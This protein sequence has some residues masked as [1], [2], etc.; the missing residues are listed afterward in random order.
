MEERYIASVDLGTSKIAVA[1]ARVTGNDVQVVYYGEEPS[2]GI[3]YGYIFNPL[4]ALAPFKTAI[5][6]A[7]AEL[8]IK[9]KQAVVGLPRY[10]VHQETAKGEIPRSD[11]NISITE[12]ELFNLKNMALENYELDNEESEIRYGA[13]AQSFNTDEMQQGQAEDI[14]GMISPYL[15]GNFK[16]FIGSRK[17]FNNI[18]KVF[19]DAGIAIVDKYFVPD[20]TAKLVLTSDEMEGGVALI[21]MGAGV[22][23]VSI[24]SRGIL[25]HY[26]SIPFGGAA[27]TNDI[28]LECSIT[29]PLAE[30][31]KIAFGNCIPDKLGP[32]SEKIIKIDFLGNIPE[33]E[34]PVRYLSE[35]IQA[36]E[37]EIINAILFE[38]QRSGYAD[39][40]RSGVVITGGASEM[41]NL[42][43]MIKDLSGYNVRVGYPMHVFS[44]SGC[45]HAVD[46]SATC[47]MSMVMAARE[48]TRLNCAEE[49]PDSENEGPGIKFENELFK[50]DTDETP[51]GKNGQE[52][53][54]VASGN[55]TGKGTDTSVKGGKTVKRHQ[56]GIWTHVDK[57]IKESL[58]TVGTLF[59]GIDDE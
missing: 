47:C 2:A 11:E 38:I 55:G 34:L 23:S 40:L 13:I 54:K 41:V 48:S 30:N 58:N 28:K 49:A 24:Y 50:M 15:E 33:K 42:P 31:I 21:D 5:G 46:T 16:V 3:R 27:I 51:G 9:I 59:D 7:E 45:A 35:I 20:S 57:A 19:N 12:E 18:D 6:K 4:K 22:T 14:I 26:A 1:V 39:E 56:I 44:A 25:R 32:D 53:G 52:S 8:G 29:T 43:T 17:S 10:Y 37:S 36:R